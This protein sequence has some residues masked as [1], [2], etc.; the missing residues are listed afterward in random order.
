MRHKPLPRLLITVLGLAFI[1]WGFSGVMLGL[2]GEETAAVITSIRREGG[3][4]NEVI[5][6]RYTYNISYTFTLPDGKKVDSF[7]KKIGSSVYVKADGTTTRPV[8]YFPAFPYINALEQ[9]TGYGLR[10]LLLIFIGGFLI[11]AVNRRL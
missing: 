7:T 9:D 10:Q 2:F 8:R 1:L 3:E 11:F 6:N 4:R 5:P